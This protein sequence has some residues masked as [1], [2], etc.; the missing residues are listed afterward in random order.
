MDTQFPS[1]RHGVLVRLGAGWDSE[2]YVTDD[3]WVLRFPKR[4]SVVRQL[5]R[6]AAVLGVIADRLPLP[7]PRFE[8]SGRPGPAFPYPFV[9]YRKLPGRPIIELPTLW[10]APDEELDAARVLGAFLT[11]LHGVSLDEL[12]SDLPKEMPDSPEHAE[13]SARTFDGFRTAHPEMARRIVEW[14][15]GLSPAQLT[16]SRPVL[17]HND[18]QAE[19]LLMS[20]STRRLTGVIDWGD[21]AT[22]SAA[23]DFVGLY[24]WL[25]RAF[26]KRVL[27]HYRG[28]VAPA[29][30]DW[31]RSRVVRLG[32]SNAEYGRLADL[33]EYVASGLRAIEL[34]L[35]A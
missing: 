12:P 25:G 24:A 14:Q 22:G 16:D 28:P 35:V 26:A 23:C 30:L 15:R 17:V 8:L 33:P 11:E 20:E 18:L 3:N 6:E 10:L 7:V 29:D 32:V 31:M 21:V 4:Q 27:T 2:T 1:L 13:E 34:A 5:E 9:G 19:H